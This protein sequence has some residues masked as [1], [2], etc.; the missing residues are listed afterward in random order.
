MS[1]DINYNGSN[2]LSDQIRKKC[3][4]FK[5]LNLQG[6]KLGDKGGALMVRHI[7]F[8]KNLNYLNLNDNELSKETGKELGQVFS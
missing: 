8:L 6:C 1:C 4:N 7:K 2:I 3:W 5:Y